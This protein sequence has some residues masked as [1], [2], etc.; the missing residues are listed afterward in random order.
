MKKLSLALMIIA[1]PAFAQPVPGLVSA[2][3]LPGW[4]DE[5]G[6]RFSA[7]DLVLEPGWKTYWRSPG[8]SGIAPHFDWEGSRNMGEVTFYWPRPEIFHEAGMRSVGYHDRMLLPFSVDLEDPEAPNDLRALIEFGICQDVCVPAMVE[9]SVRDPGTMRPDPAIL[10]AMDQQ[11]RKADTAP[12]CT[13]API[14]DG[15]VIAATLPADAVQADGAE[16][17][18]I[19]E[20]EDASIWL[21]EPETSHE[22]GQ[23]SMQVEAV[24]PSGKPEDAAG[25]ALHLMLLAGD[26]AVEFPP[27]SPV[28]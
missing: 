7:L 8:D 4:V 24:A 25:G 23:I 5:E 21:D 19:A 2:E 15:V 12:T 1:A 20:H 18:V 9:L 22:N 13:A 17:A 6:Q 16:I 27:C 11:P 14:E 10:E 3:L 26:D 28:L